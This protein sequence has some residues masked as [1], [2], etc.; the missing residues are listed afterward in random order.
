MAFGSRSTADL[1]YP[2]RDAARC[3]N[4]SWPVPL[5]CVMAT[6][7]H[8]TTRQP[9]L[10]CTPAAGS[11]TWPWMAVGFP[12]GGGRGGWQRASVMGPARSAA[13]PRPSVRLTRSGGRVVPG[14]DQ[15]GRVVCVCAFSHAA[16]CL[17]GPGLA[18]EVPG[19]GVVRVR[20]VFSAPTPGHPPTAAGAPPAQVPTGLPGRCVPGR[21]DRH[22]IAQ[23]LATLFEVPS[24][25]RRWES[26]S[27]VVR[28]GRTKPKQTTP[29]PISPLFS[30]AARNP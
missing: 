7:K 12:G 11:G 9:R 29:P 24:S 25:H 20:R 14:D 15:V 19:P 18:V 23:I 10:A 27:S 22:R 1:P 3:G 28:C 5:G 13:Q 4:N 2:D 6:A 16:M 21:A 30:T 8:L 17:L 26:V